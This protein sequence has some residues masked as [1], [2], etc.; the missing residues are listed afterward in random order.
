[1][2][3]LKDAEQNYVITLIFRLKSLV[4]NLTLGQGH[5]NLTGAKHLTLIS[6]CLSCHK[7]FE[8]RSGKCTPVNCTGFDINCNFLS[9]PCELMEITNSTSW[10]TF[11]FPMGVHQV[12]KQEKDCT[13]G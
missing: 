1:M 5:L 6:C 3:T 4:L 13:Q 2:S 9:P 11:S 8:F 12:I 10:W 7:N